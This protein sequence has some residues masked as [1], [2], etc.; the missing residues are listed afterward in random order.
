V[1]TR[2]LFGGSGPSPRLAPIVALAALIAV[3]LPAAR[4]HA[5][6]AVAQCQ[7]VVGSSPKTTVLPANDSTASPPITA[8]AGMTMSFTTGTPTAALPA[9]G[10][11]SAVGG[12]FYISVDQACQGATPCVY[13]GT[14]AG[15][16]DSLGDLTLNYSDAASAST[17]VFGGC[18]QVF[19]EQPIEKNTGAAFIGTSLFT[20][21]P[22]STAKNAPKIPTCALTG[23]RLILACT[24]SNM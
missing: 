5:K 20:Q 16:I 21:T 17:P 13:S 2:F 12:S 24:A 15:T 6:G 18:T 19:L 9:K 23:T 3:M 7:G 4:V 8:N 1:R 11:T 22:Q 10:K 14:F